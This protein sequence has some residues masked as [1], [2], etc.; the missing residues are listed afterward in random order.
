[1]NGQIRSI[2]FFVVGLIPQVSFSEK[3]DDKNPWEN[4]VEWNLSPCEN[5]AELADA[6][7]EKRFE[8]ALLERSGYYE[9][10]ALAFGLALN[11]IGNRGGEKWASYLEKKLDEIRKQTVAD[12]MRKGSDAKEERNCHDLDVLTVLRRIRGKPQPLVV[13]VGLPIMEVSFPLLP[14]ANVSLAKR[15][16]TQNFVFTLG[17]NY[18]TG[19]LA[20]WRVFLWNEQGDLVEAKTSAPSSFGG[21]MFNRVLIEDEYWESKLRLANFLKEGLT[22]GTYQGRIAYHDSATVA[23]W[24]DPRGLV[25]NF[26]DVIR[27]K[28]VPREL[29]R[30]TSIDELRPL[31]LKLPETE[32]I[33]ILSHSYPEGGTNEIP[34]DS[35]AGQ[36]IQEGWAGLPALIKLLGSEKISETQRAWGLG[37]LHTIT[38]L[39]DPTGEPGLVGPYQKKSGG[40]RIVQ[41]VNGEFAGMGTGGRDTSN[42]SGGER[43]AELQ[44]KFLAKWEQLIELG[45][46]LPV[47]TEK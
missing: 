13:G 24:D 21:G 38:G 27:F 39:M 17:G 23:G 5:L 35:A 11:E 8:E 31:V 25:F 26:S 47:E 28:V 34:V 19:R 30:V 3:G 10:K 40:F 37:I 22:P 43:N 36:L 7:L 4:P 14:V 1:M 18:R 15:K 46:R 45:I 6:E 16:D 12:G 41:S 42:Y 9:D 32:S 33:Q 2:L 44:K 20:R 29:D